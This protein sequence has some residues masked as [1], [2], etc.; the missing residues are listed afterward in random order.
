MHKS[1]LNNIKYGEIDYTS[2]C[3]WLSQYQNPRREIYNL[4][5]KNELVR[6]KKGLF[7]FGP[8]IQLSPYSSEVLANL[9]YGPSYISKEYALSYHGLIPERVENIT[10]ITP[11]RKKIFDTPIG[12]FTYEYQ[13]LEKY[14]R[15]FTQVALGG[16]RHVLMATKEKALVDR[17]WKIEN[18]K[19]EG[20]L[21]NLLYDDL[22]MNDEGMRSLSM[23]RLHY[24]CVPF[25][26]PILKCLITHVE[27]CKHA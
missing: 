9:I 16:G 10:S 12:R 22:R 27:K 11:K 1:I 24:I 14:K 26:K 6:I 17:I 15:G 2:L 13:S 8:H 23:K 20:D 4:V 18:I 19:T 25:K 7:I 5:K 21:E 3:V